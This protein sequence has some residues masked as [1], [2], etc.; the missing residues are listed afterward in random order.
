[1]EPNIPSTESSAAGRSFSSLEGLLEHRRKLLHDEKITPT[2]AV[3]LAPLSDTDS[4]LW[5]ST[6]NMWFVPEP[7]ISSHSDFSGFFDDGMLGKHE[8]LKW[9]QALYRPEAQSIAAPANS[10]LLASPQEPEKYGT[11][12]FVYASS[13]PP[14][15]NLFSDADVA[16]FTPSRSQDFSPTTPALSLEMGTLAKRLLPRLGDAMREA[17]TLANELA[18]RELNSLDELDPISADRKARAFLVQSRLASQLEY[19]FH[20]LFYY[21]MKWFD[22]VLWFREYQR[23][24]LDLRAGI[25]WYTVVQPRIDDPYFYQPFPVLPI[26]G[27]FTMDHSSLHVLF[28]CGIPVWFI[29]EQATITTSTWVNRVKTPT[30]CALVFSQRKPMLSD[31][32]VRNISSPTIIF[33]QSTF[34]ERYIHLASSKYSVLGG[35]ILS[36]AEEYAPEDASFTSPPSALSETCVN[37]RSVTT[38]TGSAS[39]SSIAETTGTHFSFREPCSGRVDISLLQA[40]SLSK[41]A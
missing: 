21:P 19:T 34:S 1:M 4:R 15:S 32:K 31:G 27:A 18:H 10:A 23:L 22:T 33:D 16:W 41:S 24:L 25:I 40:L 38:S 29:R 35:P 5:I 39:S 3:C 9:P 26:R 30:S 8:Y 7:P 2:D 17:Q 20:N 14:F 28:R 6:P 13:D 36:A 12:P 11:G 37:K